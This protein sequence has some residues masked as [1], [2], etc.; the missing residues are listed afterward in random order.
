M[1]NFNIVEDLSP[2]IQFMLYWL[3]L[4]NTALE[5]TSYPVLEISPTSPVS[6]V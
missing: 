2:S 5:M 6:L 3:T 1:F 4:R